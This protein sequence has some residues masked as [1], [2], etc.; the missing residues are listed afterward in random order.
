MR[1]D[2][3]DVSLNVK[4]IR[5]TKT[6]IVTVVEKPPVQYALAAGWS[7]MMF[8]EN[9][10]PGGFS[11]LNLPLDSYLA[12]RIS[13]AVKST[14]WWWLFNYQMANSNAPSSLDGKSVIG[15]SGN[16]QSLLLGSRYRLTESAHELWLGMDVDSRF[17][18]LAALSTSN[19]ISLIDTKLF[20]LGI[21]LSY[22]I[23]SDKYDYTTSF[24]Y[25]EPIAIK[26]SSGEIAFRSKYS[27]GVSGGVNFHFN[28]KWG[29]GTLLEFES[30]SFT[31][32][33]NNSSM[34]TA[35]NGTGRL[36]VF[37]ILIQ[38]NYN[39]GDKKKFSV[40]SESSK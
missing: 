1:V 17:F 16:L 3:K 20:R 36:A 21:G 39:F 19:N 35:N 26:V 37:Q 25:R 28:D 23:N 31:Y 24:F 30:S 38:T 12:I 8:R 9:L 4:V 10:S 27:L 33:Y 22:L 15:G 18:P 13:G 7:P 40:K 34:L 32:E 2:S 14:K 5:P 6:K 11:D 29:L